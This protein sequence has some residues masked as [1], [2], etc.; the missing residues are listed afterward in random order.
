LPLVAT[1]GATAPSC[2]VCCGYEAIK[3]CRP[4]LIFGE[5][6][7]EPVEIIER[8]DLVPARHEACVAGVSPTSPFEWSRFGVYRRRFPN[9]KAP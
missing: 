4:D 9:L 6:C 2:V 7:H 1:L 5:S 3:A 8:P